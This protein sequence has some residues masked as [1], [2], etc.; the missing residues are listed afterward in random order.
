M[1]SCC[2]VSH[3]AR[4]Q[5]PRPLSEPSSVLA[6]LQC[7]LPS[8]LPENR[9]PPSRLHSMHGGSLPK[10]GCPENF[11]ASPSGTGGGLDQHGRRFDVRSISASIPRNLRYGPTIAR[12]CSEPFGEP[13]GRRNTG[14]CSRPLRSRWLGSS[15]RTARLARSAL[16]VLDR[17]SA[18]THSNA[19]ARWRELGTGQGNRTTSGRWLAADTRHGAPSYCEAACRRAPLMPGYQGGGRGRSV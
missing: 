14:F 13:P 1:V 4:H 10:S 11:S 17:G 7:R 6:F 15:S 9:R 12:R 3:V 8:L 16:A 2:S 18:M 5:L 19:Q